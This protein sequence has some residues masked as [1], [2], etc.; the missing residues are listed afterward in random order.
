MQV[1]RNQKKRLIQKET[2]VNH[3]YPQPQ[4]KKTPVQNRRVLQN[5]NI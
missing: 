5:D 1:A 4:N 3:H 2:A